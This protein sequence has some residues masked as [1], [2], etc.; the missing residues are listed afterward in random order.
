VSSRECWLRGNVKV[1]RLSEVE[2]PAMVNLHSLFDLK[3]GVAAEE[4]RKA[5]EDFC[6]A[7]AMRGLRS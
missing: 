6:G 4:F 7:S 3:P 1:G 5:L 2:R